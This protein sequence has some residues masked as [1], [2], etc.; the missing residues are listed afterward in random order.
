MKE[1]DFD[2]FLSQ[3]GGRAFYRGLLI[4]GGLSA[5]RAAAMSGGVSY[6][7]RRCL[8]HIENELWA[9][10]HCYIQMKPRLRLFYCSMVASF[11][12]LAV[13]K[14]YTYSPWSANK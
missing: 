9:G 13:R 2:M 14:L 3:N 12:P 11:V 4:Y 7:A 8:T 5:F 10:R 6:S 1:L